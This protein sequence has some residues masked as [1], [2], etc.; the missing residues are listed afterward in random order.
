MANPLTS[1]VIAGT[2]LT[3]APRYSSDSRRVA[4]KDWNSPLPGILAASL[5]PVLIFTGTYGY[6]DDGMVSAMLAAVAFTFTVPVLAAS[7][8]GSSRTRRRNAY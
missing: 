3:P 6:F 4:P 7:S 1:L 8:R 5:L 2:V